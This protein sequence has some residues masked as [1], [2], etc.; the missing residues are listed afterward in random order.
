MKKIIAFCISAILVAD[1][2]HFHEVESH[3]N[4]SHRVKGSKHVLRRNSHKYN[5]GHYNSDD[6]PTFDGSNQM[7]NAWTSSL[8]DSIYIDQ[9]SIPGT[10]D[11]GTWAC[12]WYQTCD[13]TQTQAWSIYYQ[14]QAGARYLDFRVN[15]GD[16]LGSTIYLGH[17]SYTFKT[18]QS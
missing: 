12:R 18:L 15:L 17:G 3:K 8:S 16:N 9:L 13:I 7:Q 10:H 6:L 11:T 2:L 5:W 1:C 14:L 4:S